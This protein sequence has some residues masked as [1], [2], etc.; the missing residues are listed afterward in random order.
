MASDE[1]KDSCAR[2]MAFVHESVG[3][4]AELN[5]QVERREVY[6]TPKSFLELI[7]LYKDQLAKNRAYIE[8][9]RTRLSEGLVKLHDAQDAVV[10]QHVV[11]DLLL[12]RLAPV[13]AKRQAAPRR[14]QEERHGLGIAHH[15]LEHLH[16]LG[17]PGRTAARATAH[18]AE[19]V[20]DAAHAAHATGHSTA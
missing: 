13:G 19:N 7:A 6:T 10:R 15:L 8:L 1:I 2:H 16:G 14:L 5:R 9:L 3:V 11:V 20:G 18:A 12:Q 17:A 4:I